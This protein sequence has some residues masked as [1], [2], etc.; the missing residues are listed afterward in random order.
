[1][2]LRDFS[3]IISSINED[4]NV[5]ISGIGGTGKSFIMKQIYDYIL[6]KYKP[7]HCVLTSTTGVSA[8]NIGGKTI[9]SWSGCV[10]PAKFPHDVE[11]FLYNYCDKIM[12]NHTYR[13]RWKN[14][15]YIFIDE[16]SMLG[17]TYLDL[18]DS[19]ARY[20]HADKKGN[21]SPLPFGGIKV[22]CSGDFLQLPPVGD[23]YCFN[24]PTWKE[25]NFK[26]FILEKAFRF[27]DTEWIE[28]LK[29][30]RKGALTNN[31]IN[32][33]NKCHQNYLNQE[34]L[35]E[36]GEGIQ[37][38][39]PTKIY[40]LKKDVEEI[41]N[42]ELEKL[43]TQS[44][45]FTSF[46]EVQ[47]ISDEQVGKENIK[48]SCD[49]DQQN[50]LDQSLNIK[51][52]ILLKVG[53]Q[54]M[55]KV[56]LDTNIGLVNGSRGVVLNFVIDPESNEVC[57]RVKFKNDIHTIKPYIFELKEDNKILTRKMIPLVLAYALTVHLSQG[58][59]LDCC[60]VDCG[61]SIFSDNQAYVAL[62]RVRNPEGLFLSS[63]N[64]YKIK[65]NKEALIFDNELRKTAILI[66]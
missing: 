45:L 2:S 47:I 48:Y 27:T 51:R 1:M 6:S 26:C 42:D 44:Q 40:S 5:F 38:I 16:I 36:P 58:S 50:K 34:Y 29:R 63:F 25:L 43:K 4:N 21:V 49:E 64:K 33:F 62:S 14:I 30:V 39:I 32:L 3:S 46:D 22:I 10:L 24:S 65:A 9:H 17:S 20:V 31:D 57:V 23:D 35:S 37:K 55:L 7:E 28:C 19:V 18:L 41:N 60:I 66:N 13:K 59:T 61:N 54:V 15:K 53:A 56:N 11:K 52:Q 12:R 8:Y